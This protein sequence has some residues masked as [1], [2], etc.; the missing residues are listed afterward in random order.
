MPYF[1]GDVLRP[2]IPYGALAAL[3]VADRAGPSM[4]GKVLQSD[5]RERN[6]RDGRTPT[7][8]DH[9]TAR[10]L[11]D[12]AA[13]RRSVPPSIDIAC[14]SEGIA[15][16]DSRHRLALR[17][18]QFFRRQR[19]TTGAL[20]APTKCGR[21]RQGWSPTWPIWRSGRRTLHPRVRHRPPGVA[22]RLRRVTRPLVRR[23]RPLARPA[24]PEH[25]WPG[26]SASSKVAT[27]HGGVPRPHSR[28][29]RGAGCPPHAPGS[30][31]PGRSQ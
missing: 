19:C 5:I 27:R 13:Y 25:P 22:V 16:T 8:C 20:L 11:F 10:F 30:R 2:E 23:R 14:R 28:Q 3:V 31:S 9:W 29:G 12:F 18:T 15:I 26:S 24:R 21:E 17:S 4:I 1:C 7:G 6:K